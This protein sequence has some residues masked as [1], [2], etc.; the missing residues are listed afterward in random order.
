M[1][2]IQFSPLLDELKAIDNAIET[3][4]EKNWKSIQY[5]YT[6][7]RGPFGKETKLLMLARD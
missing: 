3:T 6:I 5:P 2:A 1:A 7:I 4:E